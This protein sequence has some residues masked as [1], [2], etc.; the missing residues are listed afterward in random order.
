MCTY[1]RTFFECKHEAWG[2]KVKPCTIGEDY[3]RG[4]LP[5]NCSLRKPHV[6][7]SRKLHKRC[8]KCVRLDGMTKRVRAKLEEC[9]EALRRKAPE[10]GEKSVKEELYGEGKVETDAGNTEGNEEPTREESSI[11]GWVYGEEGRIKTYR[12]RFSI[13]LQLIQEEQEVPQPSIL[14]IRNSEDDSVAE[15]TRGSEIAAEDV[16]GTATTDRILVQGFSLPDNQATIAEV[17]DVWVDEYIDP[18]I[19]QVKKINQEIPKAYKQPKSRLAIPV[20]TKL[21]RNRQARESFKRSES[22]EHRKPTSFQ[23]EP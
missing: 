3:Q 22:G 8:E 13:G 1:A 17:A 9:R 18:V 7:H 15:I 14:T 10:Y 11:D 16:E 23:L 19:Q 4:S 2:R 5:H 12:P 6:L 21:T 20:P